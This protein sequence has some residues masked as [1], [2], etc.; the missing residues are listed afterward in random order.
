MGQLSPSGDYLRTKDNGVTV[1]ICVYCHELV[2]AGKVIKT[3]EIAEKIHDC[4]GKRD[5]K[6]EDGE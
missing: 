4:Q 2:A 6:L 3:I 1:S 5:A